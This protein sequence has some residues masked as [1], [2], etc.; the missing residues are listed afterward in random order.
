VY[1][2]DLVIN[3]SSLGDQTI[4]LGL[5]QVGVGQ[6]RSSTQTNTTGSSA[7][8]DMIFKFMTDSSSGGLS[9]RNIGASTFT[10]TVKH[11][12]IKRLR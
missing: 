9:I 2:I 12:S 7:N 5:F 4:D 6:I 11:I 1:E 8:T 3:T 10:A